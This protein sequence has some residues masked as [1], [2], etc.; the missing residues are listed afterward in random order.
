MVPLVLGL[1][2]DI[3]TVR[4]RATECFL[5]SIRGFVLKMAAALALG[6][7]PGIASAAGVSS[8]VVLTITTPLTISYG[9]TVD[10]YANVTASDGSTPTGTISFYDGGQNICVIPVAQAGS[11]PASAGTGFAVGTH[12]L[13]AVYSGDA[14]RTGA[15]SNTV[16]VMVLPDTTAVS[17][18]SSANP[19]ATGQSVMFTASVGGTYA[20]PSGMVIFLDGSSV[21]GT[22][23]MNSAGVAT[24]NTIWFGAGSHSVTASY[25]GNVDSAAS[26]SAAVVETVNPAVIQAQSDVSVAVTGSTTVGVGRTASLTVTVV[27]KQGY[28]KPVELSCADLPTESA[29]TFGVET[30]PAGGGSTTLEVSTI[31]PHDCGSSTPYFESSGMPFAGPALAGL[32]VLFI[33]RKRRRGLKG[34]LIALVAVCGI[35]ALSGCGNCT[36]LGT[37]PGTYTFRVIG[38][39]VGAGAAA[40]SGGAVAAKVT[41]K[42]VLS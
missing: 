9:Q 29:C 39:P 17:L 28:A 13:T 6:A 3:Q 25:A 10:G 26:V 1:D 30:I 38:T 11:C 31:A 35:A 36:D 4:N 41:M 40:S 7:M 21:L 37:R 32:A 12:T 19:A 20:M 5:M 2:A 18:E 16:T 22:A 27:T 23:A 42:V 24:L 8:S 34:L 14:M 15:T 33:P